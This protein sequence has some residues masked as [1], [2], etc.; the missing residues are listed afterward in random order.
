MKA[1]VGTGGMATA[2]S[3]E[4]MTAFRRLYRTVAHHFGYGWHQ[5]TLTMQEGQ[6]SALIS[7]E[8]PRCSPARGL[9]MASDICQG[10]G[11]MVL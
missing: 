6:K 1:V 2:G 9:L 11:G 10:M 3:R 7:G 5:Q 4:R 8:R